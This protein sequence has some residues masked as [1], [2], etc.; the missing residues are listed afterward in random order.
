MI[1]VGNQCVVVHGYKLTWM[2]QKR[3][4]VIEPEPNEDKLMLKIRGGVLKGNDDFSFVNDRLINDEKGNPT[5]FKIFTEK[6]FVI[7]QLMEGDQ[8]TDCKLVFGIED[9]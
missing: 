1:Q 9:E 8:Y 4:L 3:D 5:P 6:G 7:V 2:P